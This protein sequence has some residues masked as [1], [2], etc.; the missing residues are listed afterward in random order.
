MKSSKLTR[1]LSVLLI[2]ALL[3]GGC[4]N[5]NTQSSSIVN[6]VYSEINTDLITAPSSEYVIACLNNV[7]TITGIETDDLSENNSLS[8]SPAVWLMNTILVSLFWKTA[9]LAAEASI[10]LQQLKTHRIGMNTL[11]DLMADFLIPDTTLLS[12]PLSSEP[13]NTFLKKNKQ[14]LNPVL[15]LF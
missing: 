1:I 11:T 12:V 9:H 3:L 6:N 5:T 4:G 7:D 2:L 15:S 8:S 13:L 14:H 10:F